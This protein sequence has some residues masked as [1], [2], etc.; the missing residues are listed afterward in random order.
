MAQK[1][2]LKQTKGDTLTIGTTTLTSS[3][4]SVGSA[5]IN[6]TA[7]SIGNTVITSTSITVG[8]TVVSNS[9]VSVGGS[10][11]ASG[12][13][14]AS[15]YA[16]GNDLPLTNLTAGTLAYANS[17]GVLYLTNGSGWYKVSMINQAPSVWANSYASSYTLSTEGANTIITLQATEPEGTPLIWS[18]SNSG[19]GSTATIYQSNNVFTVQPSTNTDFAGNFS[20]SFSASDG[21]NI[22]AASAAFTLSFTSTLWVYDTED[23]NDYVEA[24]HVDNND[25]FYWGYSGNQNEL[26]PTSGSNTTDNHFAVHKVDNAAS[27]SW[28][29]LLATT[30]GNYASSINLTG[31]ASSSNSVYVSYGGKVVISSSVRTTPTIVRL[32]KNTGAYDKGLQIPINNGPDKTIGIGESAL[33]GMWAVFGGRASYADTMCFAR[34][35]YDCYESGDTINTTNSHIYTTIDMNSSY[36]QSSGDPAKLAVELSDGS[37]VVAGDSYASS[38]NPNYYLSYHSW[39][40]KFNPNGQSS[41]NAYYNTPYY[42]TADTNGLKPLYMAVNQHDEILVCFEEQ[43]NSVQRRYIYVMLF[44]GTDMS[45]I[46][47]RIFRHGTQTSTSGSSRPHISFAAP[48]ASGDFV[49]LTYNAVYDNQIAWK[50]SRS[51]LS[52]VE[53][54]IV[55]GSGAFAPYSYNDISNKVKI[56][57]SVQPIRYK[58]GTNSRMFTVNVDNWPPD[59]FASGFGQTGTSN[60]SV[61][62][63]TSTYLFNGS[64]VTNFVTSSTNFTPHD[65]KNY[66]TS[67]GASSTYYNVNQTNF[68]HTGTTITSNT[69]FGQI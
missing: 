14:R 13:A 17:T 7:I 53:T 11:L 38:G 27:K 21:V 19:L 41:P 23:V 46:A 48:D 20:I 5:S 60:S 59:E 28:T 42:G 32:N 36:F 45:T 22:G 66:P 25:N 6:S 51:D 16:T 61:E 40:A 30:A 26:D 57:K 65:L 34:F 37:F 63:G 35:P 50:L 15:Q 31:I 49:C 4:L 10:P 69:D 55:Y 12:P 9:G 44:D 2:D 58:N 64:L 24:I 43:R 29:T 67:S 68:N 8:N 33:G 18:Y 54:P 56:R 1:V 3:N 62:E 39:V 47:T 52:D